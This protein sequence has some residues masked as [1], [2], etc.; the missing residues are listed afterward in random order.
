MLNLFRSQPK[1]LKNDLLS[2]LTVALTMAIIWLLPKLTKA[3]PASLVA[4]L[5]VSTIGITCNRILPSQLAAENQS[6]VI[7]TVGD[8]L[9]TKAKDLIRVSFSEEPQFHLTT[10]RLTV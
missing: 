3:L 7:M 2:G 4:I 10:D 5:V 8:M 6:N 9:A 1:N